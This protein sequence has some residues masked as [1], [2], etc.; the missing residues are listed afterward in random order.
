MRNKK[1][2][3]KL[4]YILAMFIAML[5]LFVIFPNSNVKAVNLIL[6]LDKQ[7]GR[8]DKGRAPYGAQFAVDDVVL[9][10]QKGSDSLYFAEK[11]KQ[12]QVERQRINILMDKYMKWQMQLVL[13]HMII[14]CM[15]TMMFLYFIFQ[16]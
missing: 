13:M 1:V 8:T 4:I 10:A 14:V 15:V 2:I 3:K 11:L 7:N 12:L 16:L 6:E 9:A 5:A